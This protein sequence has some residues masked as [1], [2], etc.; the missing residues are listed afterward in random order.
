MLAEK[1][2][3]EVQERSAIVT[4]AVVGAVVGFVAVALLFGA[5]VY[6]GGGGWAGVGAGV[7]VGAFGG[8]GFGS[9]MGASSAADK[10][11]ASERQN[12]R[13]RRSP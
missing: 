2:L 12:H 5:M 4:A 7:F 13:S 9:M 8:I 11:I 3:P 6:V 10:Q 1:G